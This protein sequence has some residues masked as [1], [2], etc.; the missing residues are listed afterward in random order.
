MKQEVYFVLDKNWKRDLYNLSRERHIW[1]CNSNSNNTQ[2]DEVWKKD[3]G[4]NPNI[5]ITSFEIKESIIDVFYDFLG[6]IDDHHQGGFSNVSEWKRIIVFGIDINEIDKIE[7]QEVLG[8]GVEIESLNDCF[9]II[10][11]TLQ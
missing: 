6:I 2:I 5:G 8:F 9:E 10:K 7:I 11:N 4:Y 3:K 1:I